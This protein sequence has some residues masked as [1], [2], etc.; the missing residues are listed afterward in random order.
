[1]TLALDDHGIVHVT[2]QG[3]DRF[4]PLAGIRVSEPLGGAPRLFTC[5]DDAFCE[6]QPQAGLEAFLA[7]TQILVDALPLT[8]QTRNL[9]D[10]ARL[11]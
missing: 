5:A 10:R 11:S 8:D 3:V 2:G 9:L 6:V 4:E 1:V 7:G